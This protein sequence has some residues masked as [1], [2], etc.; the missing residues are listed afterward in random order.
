[1]TNLGSLDYF[2]AWGPV[3]PNGYYSKKLMLN[4]GYKVYNPL[5]LVMYPKRVYVASM[6]LTAEYGGSGL[7]M[8]LNMA[9]TI[10]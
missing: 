4:R 8:P 6:T 10:T 3:L 7:C 5:S 9:I 2:L 1:V